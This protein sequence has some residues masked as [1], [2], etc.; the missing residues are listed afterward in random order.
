MIGV[1]TARFE[2]MI[3]LAEAMADKWE[4]CIAQFDRI[5]AIGDYDFTASLLENLLLCGNFSLGDIVLTTPLCDGYTKEFY[6]SISED[7][8][9]VE[10]LYNEKRQDYLNDSGAVAIY[11]SE[12][13]DEE[14]YGHVDA[15]EIY[16]VKIKSK[17][18]R[19][20]VA[21]SDQASRH[22]CIKITSD[23]Y[24]SKKLNAMMELL[25]LR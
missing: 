20:G 16:T 21:D 3:D 22:A 7:G 12:D 8:I 11:I 15:E 6:L 23:F 1:K 10:K 9:C 4:L 5:A 17:E 25:G 24:D 18:E 19:S 13:C 14:I 2:T